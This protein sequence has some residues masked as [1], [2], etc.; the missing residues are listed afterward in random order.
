MD[1]LLGIPLT[2]KSWKYWIVYPSRSR[3][4]RILG[5][6]PLGAPSL[7]RAGVLEVLD[8]VRVGSY[9]LLAL[10]CPAPPQLATMSGELRTGEGPKLGDATGA[11]SV[12]VEWVQ[13]YPA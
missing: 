5:Y 4:L 12:G 7:T 13:I 2:W 11:K 6:R 9:S 1:W 10:L 3:S 8:W